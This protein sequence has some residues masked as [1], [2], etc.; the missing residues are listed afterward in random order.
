V[1]GQ[2]QFETAAER[3]P[4]DRGSPRLARCFDVAE[5]LREAAALVEQHLIGGFLALGLQHVGVLLAHAFQ[6]REVS[7]GAQR[8]LA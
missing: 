8:F 2:R 7:A 4:V 1:A 3:Q 6:H 5:H